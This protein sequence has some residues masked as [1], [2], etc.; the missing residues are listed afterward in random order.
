MKDI[1]KTYILDVTCFEDK[2]L[3]KAWYDK[4]DDER[5]KKIDAF[6]PESSKRLS[7]GAGVAIK[8]ALMQALKKDWS[9]IAEMDEFSDGVAELEYGPQ[10]KPFIKGREDLYF[11]VSHPG[12]KVFLGISDK[13]IGVDIEKNKEFKDSLVN[14]VFGELDKKCAESLRK[15]GAKKAEGIREESNVKSAEGIREESN[16]KSAEGIREEADAKHAETITDPVNKAFTRLWT[17]KES[18]MK[19]CGMGI[20]LAPKSIELEFDGK[21]ITARSGE[22]DLT[23]LK[24]TSFE[25]EGYQMTICSEYADFAEPEDI[26]Q[27]IMKG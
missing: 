4:M 19:H 8:Y 23:K 13:E 26:T 21:E 7:L 25:T 5:K 3:F 10:G 12:N 6:K 15:I 22:L 14:Y 17:V 27:E 11:N 18:I 9:E 2:D 20:S 16:V 24:L 1:N